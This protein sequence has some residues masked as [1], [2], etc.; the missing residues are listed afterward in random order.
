MA[1]RILIIED[2]KNIARVLE[3]ELKYEGYETGVAHTGSEGLIEFREHEWDLVLLDLMLP[4]IPGLDVLK[5][6]RSSNEKLPV[7]L[8]TAKK[9][10]KRQSGRLGSW[11]QRLRHKTIRNRGIAC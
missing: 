3:L 1:E 8:L 4:E 9:R 11:S 7:I 6:I 10:S 5:R 2:E